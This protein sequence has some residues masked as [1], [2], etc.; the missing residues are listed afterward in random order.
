LRL[1][2]QPLQAALVCLYAVFLLAVLVIDLEH[3]VVL[4]VMLA[5]AAVAALVVSILPGGPTPEQA[6]VGGAV[7]FAAFFVIGLIGRG[8]LGYGDVKLAGVIGLMAG[9]PSVIAALFAGILLGGLAALA[10]IIARKATRKTAIAYAPYLVLGALAVI[11][12]HGSR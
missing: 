2:Q 11:L 3:R 8:A 12:V 5:P 7:G 6:L 9:Y 10:L 4:N 1:G